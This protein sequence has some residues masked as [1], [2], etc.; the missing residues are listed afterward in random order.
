MSGRAETRT[1]GVKPNLS[2]LPTHKPVISSDGDNVIITLN[3]GS[4][5]FA[6][7]R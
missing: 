6:K 7:I 4:G 1:K 2:R 5:K 3:V